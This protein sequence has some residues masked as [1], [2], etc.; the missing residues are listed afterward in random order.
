MNNCKSKSFRDCHKFKSCLSARFSILI[1]ELADRS[2][3]MHVQDSSLLAICNYPDFWAL[4]SVR[5]KEQ[6]GSSKL[7]PIHAS[8]GIL[9][10]TLPVT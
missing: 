8:S 4:V 10:F 9:G 6:F 3:K 7:N 1:T 5:I 2:I